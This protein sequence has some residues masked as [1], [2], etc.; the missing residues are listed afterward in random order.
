MTATPKRDSL[1]SWSTLIALVA[2][3]GG[4]IPATASE[5][6]QILV[7]DATRD[8][9]IDLFVTYVPQNGA[10]GGIRFVAAHQSVVTTAIIRLSAALPVDWMV[11]VRK[12]GDVAANVATRPVSDRNDYMTFAFPGEMTVVFDSGEWQIPDFDPTLY[13]VEAGF[14][15]EGDVIRSAYAVP[16]QPE[17][18]LDMAPGH[19]Q[20]VRSDGE[21]RTGAPI[22]P[23]LEFWDIPSDTDSILTFDGR[24]EGTLRLLR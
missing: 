21:D 12:A 7:I 1:P 17:Q 20:V 13:R 6:A 4:I 23:S 8:P 9:G 10:D 22:K 2:A 15:F 14:G 24:G 19:Y 11:S 3:V 16:C 18:R 5:P